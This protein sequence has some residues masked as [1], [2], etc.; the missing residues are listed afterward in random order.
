MVNLGLYDDA[1]DILQRAIA[2]C[3]QATL[4]C[5]LWYVSGLIWSKRLYN[6]ARSNACFDMAD[7][8]LESVAAEDGGD[9][10]M[11]RAWVQNG[12]A[13]NAIPGRA[14]GAQAHFD[15]LPDCLPAI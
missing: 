8:A 4:R 5:H 13:M 15:C 10:H 14:T 9:P 1:V 3:D 7:A 2:I 12:R 6:V 11:E